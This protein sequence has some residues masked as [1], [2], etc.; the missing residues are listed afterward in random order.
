MVSIKRNYFQWPWVTSNS[1]F[2]V[3]IICN[4]NSTNS[5]RNLFAAEIVLWPEIKNYVY[6]NAATV[7]SGVYAGWRGG[8]GASRDVSILHPVTAEAFWLLQDETSGR[9]AITTASTFG[10]RSM[11]CL[12]AAKHLC[13]QTLMLLHCIASSTI[14]SLAFVHPL[15]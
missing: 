13:H 11:S 10:G 2:K 12:V 14:R 5:T 9:R 1:R 7:A 15:L 4:V 3:T 8:H 6:K